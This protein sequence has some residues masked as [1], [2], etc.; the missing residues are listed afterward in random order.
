MKLTS[1][2]TILQS[3]S[4]SFNVMK[5]FSFENS[6]RINDFVLTAPGFF[7]L[8][9]F[10]L[11]FVFYCFFFFGFVF[12]LFFFFWLFCECVCVCVCVLFV[13][14]CLFFQ[15]LQHYY[16]SNC[17]ATVIVLG[18]GDSDPS[19]NPERGCFHFTSR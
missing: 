4:H 17:E 5:I 19:S 1:L 7:F 14:V 15:L 16:W 18:S 2:N 8:F 10:Y 13:F 9:L 6:L 11:C 3:T 12:L